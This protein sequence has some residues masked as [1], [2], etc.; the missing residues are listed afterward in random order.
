MQFMRLILGT[1]AGAIMYVAGYNALITVMPSGFAF[2]A[3]IVA[4]ITLG[5]LIA[6]KR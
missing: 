2:P 1:I 6:K 3:A 5:V 4:A